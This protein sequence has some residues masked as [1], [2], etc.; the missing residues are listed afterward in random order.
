VVEELLELHR[1][2]SARWPASHKATAGFDWPKGF[3]PIPTDK[4]TGD[5]VHQAGLAYDAV[6]EHGWYSNLDPLV[7]QLAANLAD[8]DIL[9]DYS[10]G[11]GILLDRLR[12]RIFDRQVGIVIVDS[13]AKF[14]RVALEKYK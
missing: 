8:G 9:L 7:E 10:G 2:V 12:L 14:L 3:D 4:W 1:K 5:D 13:S 11:T 6:D